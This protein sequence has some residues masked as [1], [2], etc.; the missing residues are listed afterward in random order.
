MV[1]HRCFFFRSKP[2][3]KQLNSHTDQN[4]IISKLFQ[5]HSDLDL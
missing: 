3:D 5:L 1:F 4:Y 2:K